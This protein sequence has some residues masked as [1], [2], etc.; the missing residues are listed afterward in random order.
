VAERR[1]LVVGAHA[2]DFVWRAAGAIALTTMS[3]GT[4]KAVALS[5]GARGES[6]ELWAQPGQ[7]IQSVTEAR[8]NEATAAAAILGAEFTCLGLDDYPLD[9][10]SEHLAGLADLMR[11][12]R[13]TVVV[14]H[15]AVDPFNPDHPVAHA[16]VVRAQQL[17][18]GAGRAAAFPIIPQPRV[19]LFE[20][21]YPD[22]SGFVPDVFLDITSAHE[23]K[24][25]AMDAIAS[26]QYM[27]D[28]QIMRSRQ[29]AWQ[30]RRIGA[31]PDIEFA[32][33]FERYTPEV[34]NSL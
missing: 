17:A 2:A 11:D 14:T 10:D 26:Q 31:R 29:R 19:L 24:A 16:A 32:E 25:A 8:R 34:V 9:V 18:T 27:P 20:P 12:F 33:V 15:S 5:W 1:L 30:A 6:G 22:S 4:A 13:P 21:H 23:L 28:Y 7:T 3:G